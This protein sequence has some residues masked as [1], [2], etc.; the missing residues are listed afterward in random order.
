MGRTALPRYL[1]PLAALATLAGCASPSRE[2]T[3]GS[4]ALRIEEAVEQEA[5]SRMV[6]KRLLGRESLSIGGL[7][8]RAV[9]EELDADG[10]EVRR[11]S[12]PSQGTREEALAA[13]RAGGGP[14][15]LLV[16]RMGEWDLDA[17]FTAG[18]ATVEF[19]FLILGVSDGRVI[20]TGAVPRRTVTLRTGEQRDIDAFVRRLA[21][22]TLRSRP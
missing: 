15:G 14:E 8:A 22:E 12:T 20:W 6:L 4:L 19:E 10:I 2:K 13:L 11:D 9:E 18:Q 17:V 21:V 16:V 7:M 1:F 5:R 3:P